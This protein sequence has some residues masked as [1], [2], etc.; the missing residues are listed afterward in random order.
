M[1]KIRIKLV[2]IAVVL[3]TGFARDG[4]QP[5]ELNYKGPQQPSSESPLRDNMRLTAP[6]RSRTSWSVF[7][8]CFQTQTIDRLKRP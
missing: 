6:S 7:F 2:L 4:S 8:D 5:T 1:A 3:V